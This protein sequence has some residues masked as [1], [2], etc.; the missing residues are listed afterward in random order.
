MSDSTAHVDQTN[1][2]GY[3]PNQRANLWPESLGTA[4]QQQAPNQ[5]HSTGLLTLEANAGRVDTDVWTVSGTYQYNPQIGPYQGILDRGQVPS[6]G[7]TVLLPPGTE[8]SLSRQLG[9]TL[10]LY[11]ASCPDSTP[12]TVTIDGKP[13]GVFGS[14]TSPTCTARRT[15]LYRG[16]LGMHTLTITPTSGNVYVYAAEWTSAKGGIEVDNLAVGGATTRFYASPQK[17]AY[18]GVIPNVSLVILALG[19]NDFAHAIPTEEYGINLGVIITGIRQ[20]SPH[21]SILIVN[22]YRVLSDDHR[23]SV[24]LLQSDYAAVAQRVAHE[25]K[26]G[27]LDMA[28]AW[29]PFAAENARGWLTKDSVHPS[30]EG[31]RQF[32]C[33]LQRVLLPSHDA[34]CAASGGGI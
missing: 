22:Q 1:G 33:E 29:G 7:G 2:I 25:Q 21:A 20:L 12:F 13:Q 32:S 26:V 10:W 24:N 30:D 34:P 27:Y 14:E 15:R 6:N 4:L 5:P 18:V 23:S 17:L 3:G 8:A 16:P 11:W 9:D 28:A 19:I 31:G